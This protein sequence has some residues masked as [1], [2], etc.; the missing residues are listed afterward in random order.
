MHQPVTITP[1][2]KLTQAA[3]VTA[4]ALTTA[5]HQATTEMDTDITVTETGLPTETVTV[6]DTHTRQHIT[7]P[8]TTVTQSKFAK[9]N[10]QTHVCSIQRKF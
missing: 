7:Q 4:Q 3:T 5:T 2:T 10:Q 9:T 8:A 1:L 6:T